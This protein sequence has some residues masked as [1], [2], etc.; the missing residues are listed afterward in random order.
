MNQTFSDVFWSLKPVPFCEDHRA[1]NRKNVCDFSLCDFRQ[2]EKRKVA[3]SVCFF[4]GTC[5]FKLT[6]IPCP[7]KASVQC[8]LETM[9]NEHRDSI[10]K[11]KHIKGWWPFGCRPEDSEL[12]L[13][14]KVEVEL[15]LLSQ[16]EAEQ[17]PAGLGRKEPNPL[18]FP[19]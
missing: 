9:N 12:E 4:V 1:E 2:S 19:Q 18:P 14:G 10:F 5:T 17:D 11:R 6:S 8:T 13:V 7:A 3:I 15:E 16:Q